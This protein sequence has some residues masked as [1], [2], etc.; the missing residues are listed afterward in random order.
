MTKKNDK[1]PVRTQAV[2]SKVFEGDSQEAIQQLFQS[3][4]FQQEDGA[5]DYADF[6]AMLSRMGI[7][8]DDPRLQQVVDDL[9]NA[10]SQPPFDATQF[11]SILQ[12]SALLRKAFT[13][14]LIIPDFEAFAEDIATI[15]KKVQKNTSG[16]VATYIPQ[17]ERVDPEQFAVSI[18]TVDGQRFSM[19]DAEVPFC[20][21]STCKTINYCIAHEELGEAKVHQHIGREPSGRSFNE[22]SLNQDGLPHNPLINAGAIMCCSLIRQ[23]EN[24]ADRFDSVIQTWERLTAGRRPHFDNAVYLSERETADRNFAL[25][26]FMREKKAFPPKTNI[27]NTLEFYFQCCSLTLNTQDAAVAMATLANSGVCPL[28]DDKVFSPKTVQDCLS[29][30][31]SCGMYD[32]SGEFAF[33]IG[34]PAKSGVSGAIMVVVPNL[35]GMCIWSPRLDKIGNSARG[36]EFCDR[37][38]KT[39][40]FHNYDNICEVTGKKDPRLKRYQSKSESLVSLIWAAT[41][42][43]VEEINRLEATG[44]DLNLPDYDGRT[45]LHL[46]AA[47]GQLEAVEYLLSQGVKPNP[48]DRWG[49][50]PLDDAQRYNH[51]QIQEILKSQ[52]G[53]ARLNSAGR[54]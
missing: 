47:E 24:M 39:Y 33:K 11:Q 19:G 10:K 53:K 20:L 43:D 42:G 37:L 54:A 17:L 29:L 48:V 35:L 14:N 51:A 7:H 31:F 26:Y 6:W 18:C 49:G 1:S 3:L 36:I 28:N 21:Q 9:E 44:V 27:E 16:K 22:L 23:E 25:S 50:T 34:L 38:V 13:G 12:Q 41:H 45:A 52:G 2:A 15:F 8:Q 4:E 46:A 5:V 32:F 30:M 40:N